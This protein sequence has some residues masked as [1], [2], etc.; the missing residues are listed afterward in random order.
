MVSE[1][2]PLINLDRENWD[3]ENINEN[4]KSSK[5]FEIKF[6]N[7]L[8]EWLCYNPKWKV[9]HH[10][11]NFDRFDIV[12]TNTDFP[13]KKFYI[14]LECGT[15][16]EEWISSIFNNSRWK[17]LNVLTRKVVQEKAKKHYDLFIKHNKNCN[18]FWTTTSEFALEFGVLKTIKTKFPTNNTVF[19]L[20][21]KTVA[22]ETNRENS[23]ICFDDTEKLETLIY[24]LFKAKEDEV[25][26]PN[27]N[28]K[29]EVVTGYEFF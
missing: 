23:V 16:Q 28:K 2:Q 8:S 3:Q 7:Q 13:K 19:A 1:I 14:E 11:S 20:E 18:S 27:E 29:N 10:Y 25:I 24:R 12:L 17:S 21:W 9:K 4:V 22:E 15:E 5:R 26:H 6:L